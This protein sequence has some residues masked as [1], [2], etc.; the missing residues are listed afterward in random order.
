MPN[1]KLNTGI[2]LIFYV[3]YIIKTA[4]LKLIAT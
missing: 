3:H 1:V 2:F 4:K